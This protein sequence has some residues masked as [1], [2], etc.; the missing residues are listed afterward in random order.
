MLL[1]I[2]IIFSFLFQF[3]IFVQFEEN[4]E[5]TLEQLKKENK[6]QFYE[7]SKEEI[8]DMHNKFTDS[9]LSNFL[10]FTVS[11]LFF[12]NLSHFQKFLAI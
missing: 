4:L 6:D 2:V 9:K 12:I 5:K 11:K 7:L 1:K 8:N 3:N 10:G